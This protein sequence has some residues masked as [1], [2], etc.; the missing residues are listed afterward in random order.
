MT[1]KQSLVNQNTNP[2]VVV[3]QKLDQ[4]P[5]NINDITREQIVL[6]TE[7]LIGWSTPDEMMAL[8]KTTSRTLFVELEANERVQVINNLVI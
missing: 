1:R 3:I 7:S 6:L 5:N 8:A 4:L 2:F